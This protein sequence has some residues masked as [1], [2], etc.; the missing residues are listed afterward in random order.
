MIQLDTQEYVSALRE[1]TE[2]GKEVSMRI[3]GSSMTPFLVH[4]RDTVFFKKPD[5][6]LKKGDIVFYQ[7]QNGRYILHRVFDI[8]EN[9]YYMVGDAQQQIE[10]PLQRDQIFAVVTRACRK[11]KM[12]G[13][14]DFWWEFFAKVWIRMVGGRTVV[15]NA[16]ARMKGGTHGSEQ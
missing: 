7:R 3:W 1:L 2:Q 4:E 14:G 11:G 12:I 13:P 16:Y 6:P 5:R 8:K 10:G 15:R 9:G